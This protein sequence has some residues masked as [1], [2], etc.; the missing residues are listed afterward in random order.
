MKVFSK[1]N[2]IFNNRKEKLAFFLPIIPEGVTIIKIEH[3]C[4]ADS[5]KYWPA[6]ENMTKLAEII[7]KIIV[8]KIWASC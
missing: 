7:Q 5:F 3:L 2:L 6:P 8:V 4:S 1:I